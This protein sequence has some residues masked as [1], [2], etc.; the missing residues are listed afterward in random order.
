[1]P[2][3]RER[4]RERERDATSQNQG[5]PD[6]IWRPGARA[7]ASS[8]F[9]NNNTNPP[10]HTRSDFDDDLDHTS[11]S[12]QSNRASFTSS[13]S[14]LSGGRSRARGHPSLPHQWKNV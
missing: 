11:A 6:L 1:M 14:R 12:S 8:I 10:T 2:E 5:G 9:G 7:R 13:S 4:E 3:A